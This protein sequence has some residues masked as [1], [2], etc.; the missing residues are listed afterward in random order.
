MQDMIFQLKSKVGLREVEIVEL[1][2]MLCVL[3]HAIYLRFAC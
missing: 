3:T 1:N 2:C